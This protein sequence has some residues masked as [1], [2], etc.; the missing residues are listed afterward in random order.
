M[1]AALLQ[2]AFSM[3]DSLAR[4]R[5]RQKLPAHLLYGVQ[6]EDAAYFHLLSQGYNVV[7]RRWSTRKLRGDVDLIAWQ[8]ELLC[9]FEVKTRTSRDLTP[10]HTAVDQ[11][12]RRILRSLARAYVRQLSR[13]TS[14][15][16]RPNLRFD[17]IA[18]YL[19]PGHQPE[20]E[21]YENS[22]GWDEQRDRYKD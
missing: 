12:K 22:F 17:V 18:V 13:N 5:G 20:I 3:L 1:R 7:A 16:A 14:T 11:H 10:A 4:L 15:A 21:H 19:I 6:G 2:R 8:G 9:F